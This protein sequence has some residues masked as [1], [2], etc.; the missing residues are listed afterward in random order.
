VGDGRVQGPRAVPWL[1]GAGNKENM[2]L[3]TAV[4][5]RRGAHAEVPELRSGGPV[6]GMLRHV[7][8]AYIGGVVQAV[9][10]EQKAFIDSPGVDGTP[11]S[12]L[13]RAKDETRLSGIGG[14]YKG[15]RLSLPGIE[16]SSKGKS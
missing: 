15:Q 16:E 10:G 1:V 4:N 6:H 7:K 2:L 8:Y 5:W 12:R 13:K 3:A 14:E 11:R 9:G